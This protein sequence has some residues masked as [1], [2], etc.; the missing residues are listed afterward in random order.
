MVTIT[1]GAK[2]NPVNV[3]AL[4]FRD[5]TVILSLAE[6]VETM[7]TLANVTTRSLNHLHA[8]LAVRYGKT[9]GRQPRPGATSSVIG[10]GE[11]GRE[12]NDISDVDY[13]FRVPRSRRC[14]L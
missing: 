13:T 5:I 4:V 11:A 9:A 12:L 8:D 7:T 3:L 14:C 1:A 6:I 10:M 2:N